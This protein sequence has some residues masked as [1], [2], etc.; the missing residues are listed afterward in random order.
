M[1]AHDP[2]PSDQASAACSSLVIAASLDAAGVLSGQSGA[3]ERRVADLRR[4]PRQHALLAARSDQRRQLQQARSRLALQDRP[5]RAAAGVPVRVDAADGERRRSTPRRHAARG[6]RARRRDR[7]AAVDAQRAR[8]RAR[9]RGAA[10]AVR[11]AASPTGPTAARNGSSTS[12][13]ATG[14]SRSMRRPALRIPASATDGVVDLKTGRRSGDRSDDS[15]KSACT[16]TPVVAKNVVIVGAAHRSGGVPTGK[17]QR[18]RLRARI[19]RAD[20]QAAL[21]LPHHSRRRASSA[22]TPGRTIRGPTPA[23]PASGRRSASTKSSAWPICR[24]NCRPA[25]TT[26]A[27]GR[28]TAC[29]ARASSPSICRPASASGTTSWC[30]TASG[31]WTFRA[32]RSSPTSSSTAG[33]IKAV[34][35]PT[36]QAFLYVF[37]RVTGEPI[38]PIEERPVAKGDVPGE[39]YSPTQPFPLTHT[40]PFTTTGRDSSIDD[41]IDF[42]PELRAE[43]VQIAVEVQA[44]ADLHAA[45]RQQ[46]RG[47]LA[48][49]VAGRRP[50]AARTGRA[51]R[52]IPRRTSCTCRRTSRSAQLGLVPPRDPTKND[53]QYVQGNAATGARTHGAAPAAAPRRR[54]LRPPARRLPAAPPRRRRRRWRRRTDRPGPADHE[55]AVRPD[56][57]DRSEQGRDP[58]ADRARR[59]AGQHHEQP[60]AEGPDDSAHRPAG[61]GRHARDQDAA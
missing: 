40:P 21:D 15:A 18:Q 33:P 39:W 35:Q 56:Q 58:L 37:D 13:R 26:A 57:R 4:R 50:A 31:T 44:R 49:L 16:A 47:P 46:G 19:R 2:G 30:I 53:M 48:T 3:E 29:S 12:R 59:D 5:S 27:I 7:R 54:P 23:T 32:R 51:A 8:R 60:G 9:R 1:R 38:W 45:G 43:A 61:H 34:A 14:W 25:T 36:K 52:T 24:S 10:A 22:T 6:R 17:T 41:L 20:R 42:T 55:A 11:A 28:A